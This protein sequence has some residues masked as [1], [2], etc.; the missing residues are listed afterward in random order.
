MSIKQDKCH[1]TSSVNRFD[2][3]IVSHQALLDV[4]DIGEK[5]ANCCDLER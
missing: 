1:N 4:A 2:L 3:T 5:V